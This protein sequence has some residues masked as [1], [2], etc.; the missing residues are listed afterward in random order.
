MKRY[1]LCRA[2][3]L[4]PL[5]SVPESSHVDVSIYPLYFECDGTESTLSMCD[6]YTLTAST[7]Q[8]DV[9]IQCYTSSKYGT[10]VA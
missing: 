9:H 1:L 8:N 7:H 10:S 3:K 6:V 2:G 5:F 4:F